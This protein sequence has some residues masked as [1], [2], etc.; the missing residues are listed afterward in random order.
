MPC[1]ILWGSRDET[2]GVATAYKLNQELPDAWLRVVPET[3]HSLM[4]E[5]P[6]AVAAEIAQFLDGHGQ[7][8]TR[9]AGLG[10][11]RPTWERESARAGH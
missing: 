8:W 7:G 11:G 4:W 9:T 2:F 3:G 5:R 1:L 6:A 10:G